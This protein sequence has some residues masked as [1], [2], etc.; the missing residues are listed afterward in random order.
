MKNLIK[1]RLTWWQKILLIA[2]STAVFAGA[3]WLL[4]EKIITPVY[5][6]T[7]RATLRIEQSAMDEMKSR[8]SEFVES[9]LD[10]PGSLG[11]ELGAVGGRDEKGK[12]YKLIADAL[13]EEGITAVPR[14]LKNL[15]SVEGEDAA[16]GYQTVRI[17]LDNKGT[18]EMAEA[19]FRRVIPAAAEQ[20]GVLVFGAPA[21]TDQMTV[22]YAYRGSL[23][24]GAGDGSYKDDDY[25][26]IE[27]NPEEKTAGVW[28]I[29]ARISR[30]AVDALP[31][32]GR[33]YNKQLEL[34]E[35]LESDMTDDDYLKIAETAGVSAK[36][37]DIRKSL[38]FSLT[39]DDSVIQADCVWEN[40][41][42]EA[43]RLAAAGAKQAA[44][45]IFRR[46][47]SLTDEDE[48]RFRCNWDELSGA[49]EPYR[50]EVVSVAGGYT[51]AFWSERP[52][53]KTDMAVTVR[54][55]ELDLAGYFEAE[56]GPGGASSSLFSQLAQNWSRKD[57]LSEA[58]QEAWT[59]IAGDSALYMLTAEDVRAA[60]TLEAEDPAAVHVR[61]DTDTLASVL[62]A[63]TD[64]F[65]ASAEST[66]KSSVEK[67]EMDSAQYEEALLRLH[68]RTD[69]LRES[70]AEIKDQMTASF[71][72]RLD[73]L[74]FGYA[75][76]K[77]PYR[78]Y[79][80]GIY[81]IT[82]EGLD[83]LLDGC[84]MLPCPEK[85]LLSRVSLD[86]SE[87]AGILDRADT[88]GPAEQLKS[89]MSW[90]LGEEPELRISWTDRT[91]TD[92]LAKATLSVISARL[93]SMVG[94]PM[95]LV[96][97]SSQ[98]LREQA[99]KSPPA[100][101]PTVV[102]VALIALILSYIVF[103]QQPLFDSL[104]VIFFA[105]FTL[106]CIFPFYYLLINTISDNSLVD[107]GRINFV[108]KGL[109][110]TNYDRI[111]GRQQSF[112][113]S[114]GWN[115]PE[116]IQSLKVTL[117]RTILGTAL[118]VLTSAWAG[119]LVTKQKMWHRS[120]WY[121]ALVITMY[122]NAGLIPWYTN[123]LMLGLTGNFLAYIIPGMVA[124]YNII[125]VKT[126]IESIPGSLEES[127]II[128]GA[129]TIKVF[130]RIILPL[131]VP[132]LATIAI[133]GAV[134]NWNSFQ[135]SYL[136]MSDT[137][138]LYTLQH[139]LYDY[140]RNTTAIDTEQIT[141]QMARNLKNSSITTK[142]TIAMVT[143]IPILLVYPIMQRYFVKGIML[144]AVKG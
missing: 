144:G 7:M 21:S 88:G 87:C 4:C 39:S 3:A 118:M 42:E 133:F 44:V 37:D 82:D 29:T 49:Y 98:V 12:Y 38:T 112:D 33:F 28:M 6:D 114:W 68:E 67:G 125:L 136:L 107:A 74:Y 111:L 17:R 122:F 36:A 70:I 10:I 8:D 139:R 47:L 100:T 78:E 66:L 22:T 80:S 137:P 58:G 45:V 27:G 40:G 55:M 19:D 95:R 108:P 32:R 20:F 110:L 131:S 115:N 116:I 143:I 59:D 23:K 142:Y 93:T 51:Q 85:D 75:E 30:S 105:V 62:L 123:M 132:I 61:L 26:W 56:T 127:A 13:L 117:G 52:Q 97:Q 1:R 119:Y 50:G 46:M 16:D 24:E 72:E 128:D 113:G 9:V 53:F 35:L 135:D 64:T 2:A 57:F 102:I 134:G 18:G 15:I 60:V 129:S 94:Q 99:R 126:Y 54:L 43:E 121:R 25:E 103:S 141:D 96:R 79:A 124:P 140:L 89:C 73:I 31:N 63:Q 109:H 14:D 69:T 48:M 65:V 138:S 5:V 86:E 11:T 81:R 84:Y 90:E 91:T 130:L 92:A 71:L 76:D 101:L 34:L 120:F 83:A 104:I 77:D 41:Q 106:I